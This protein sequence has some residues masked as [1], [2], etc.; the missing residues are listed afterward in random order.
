VATPRQNRGVAVVD[1]GDVF[2][3]QWPRILAALGRYTGSIELAEDSIQLA[4]ERAAA[5]PD[6]GLLLN[7]AAWIT[8]VAKR[9]AIDTV[10]RDATLRG[11]LPLLAAHAMNDQAA[12]TDHEAATARADAPGGDDRLGLLFVTCTP[13]LPAET[14]LALA[15]RFVGGLPTR[16]VASV[17]LVGH[18]AMNARITR[19]KK[20]IEHEGIRFDSPTEFDISDRLPDVLTTI[21]ALYTVAHTATVSDELGSRLLAATAIELARALHRSAPADQEVA[22]LLALR[23][24]PTPRERGRLDPAGRLVTLE[25]ADRTLWDGDL[26]LEGLDLATFALPGGG[27]FALEAGI[28]GLHCQAPDWASTDWASISMLY[29]RLVSRWPSPSAQIARIVAR[30]FSQLG[31]QIA[32]GE[33]DDLPSQGVLDRQVIAARADILR[34]LGRT[35]EARAAYGLA[36]SME[37]NSP[38]RA[39]F[40]RR[41]DELRG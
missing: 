30:S 6:R 8:T 11:K 23:L 10:R 27:Q 38:V 33:L 26:I 14:R 34:R 18:A 29:D 22:G 32:L 31:P 20:Q 39:Y 12:E 25:N 28:S 3:A 17:M 19:A 16:E 2:R 21:H 15:L 24:L 35:Q 4:F 36:R 7:P 41:I 1:L 5:A 40:E 13:A 9:I 37:Q